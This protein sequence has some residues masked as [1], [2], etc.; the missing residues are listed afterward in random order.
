M[1]AD[2]SNDPVEFR[3][4][5]LITMDMGFTNASLSDK[6][7]LLLM[8]SN[9]M[10]VHNGKHRTLPGL[11]TI[12]YSNYWE[13]FNLKKYLP[14]GSDWKAGFP[15]RQWVLMLPDPG[16]DDHYIFHPYRHFP[17]GASSS[18]QTGLLATKVEINSRTP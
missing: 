7:G 3:Y 4:D 8:Y 18:V 13:R 14:D 10:H 17:P 5:S 12:S 1:I 2:F 11:D 16:S 9:G 15:G 6:D